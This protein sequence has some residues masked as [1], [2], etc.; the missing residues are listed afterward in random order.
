MVEGV[1][2]QQE[3][4]AIL[5]VLQSQGIQDKFGVR[6][7]VFDHPELK[8]VLFNR[9]LVE[10]ISQLVKGPV[11]CIKSIYFDK[12]P[13]ANWI[14][15][16]HQDLTINLTGPGGHHGFRNW[17]TNVE[18]TV[19][20][21]PCSMLENILTVRIHL[22]DCT[23]ENGALRVIDRSHAKGVIDI[24]DWSENKVGEEV[25]CPVK[26]GGVLLMRPL[27]LHA[28]RR[29]ENEMRRRV[30]HLEFSSDALPDGLSWKEAFSVPECLAQ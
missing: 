24:K 28:S 17:R 15:N 23:A 21:P 7:V 10:L 13:A 26:R 9:N 12:P 27:V 5:H 8:Q 20:Q 30:L 22:D 18:R 6:Q 3:V 4:D 19:V 1:Y 2:S 25:I 14:V 16:W 11:R 29:T